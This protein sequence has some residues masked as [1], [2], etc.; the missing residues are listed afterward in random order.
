MEYR[1]QA[2]NAE[3][4]VNLFAED[5]LPAGAIVV[6]GLTGALVGAGL[7]ADDALRGP[8]LVLGPLALALGGGGRSQQG[9]LPLGVGVGRAAKSEDGAG[10]RA[11]L[12]LLVQ[13]YGL[14]EV[15][16]GH[17]VLL[18]RLREL[19]D[20]LH[21]FEGGLRGGDVLDTAR[22]EV[23]HGLAHQHAVA[24][25]GPVEGVGHRLARHLVQPRQRLAL[26]VC[27][28]LVEHLCGNLRLQSHPEV[29]RA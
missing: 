23:V 19:V 6:S 28:P 9:P 5:G 12:L 17:A 16:D 25:F 14:E 4:E 20:V 2:K 21:L 15:V 10:D 11:E 13:V 22:H 1:L 26:R 3:G 18:A 8:Q 7:H 27:V 29:V 24:Q